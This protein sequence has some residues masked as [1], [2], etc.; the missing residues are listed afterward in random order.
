[1]RVET[2]WKAAAVLAAATAAYAIK[3]EKQVAAARAKEAGKQ[4]A[5]VQRLPSTGRVQDHPL[6]TWV[7][8]NASIFGWK[9]VMT[10]LFGDVDPTLPQSKIFLRLLL[11]NTASNEL[12]MLA[13][14]FYVT[15]LYAHVPYFAEKRR[16]QS[17][18]EVVKD[19][20]SC[21]FVVT[22][23]SSLLFS[24]EIVKS[25]GTKM[26][27]PTFRPLRFLARV[28]FMRMSVDAVFWIGHLI[29]HQKRWYWMHKKHHE[30][31]KTSLTTNYHF[32]WYDLV[33][34]GFI[35]FIIGKMLME[36]FH[37]KISSFETDLMAGY[38]FS[39]EML[40]HAGKPTPLMSIVPPLAPFTQIWD[41]RNTWAHELH[42]RVLKANYSISYYFDKLLGTSRWE[43][44]VQKNKVDTNKEE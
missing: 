18:L 15:K 20:A 5:G 42:H 34:E 24:R 4:T 31:N 33:I 36:K 37:T 19:Y 40:S 39:Y 2:E 1:M 6:F 29:M 23:L 43:Q 25:A 16:D 32:E 38:V 3:V 21:N 35:P 7:L 17:F 13:N 8:Q 30:H 44:S 9:G 14:W 41:D 11:Q 27:D 10:K 28:A 12:L 26:P 22:I